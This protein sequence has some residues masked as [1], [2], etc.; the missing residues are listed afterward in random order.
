MTA[1]D[2]RRLSRHVEQLAAREAELRAVRLA[3]DPGAAILAETLRE[4]RLSLERSAEAATDREQLRCL[5]PSL[6]LFD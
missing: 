3:A 1:T 6:P 4:R 2:R 5:A